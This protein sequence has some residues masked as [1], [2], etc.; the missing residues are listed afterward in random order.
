M[1]LRHGQAEWVQDLQGEAPNRESASTI[2]GLREHPPEA[3]SFSR[4]IVDR[5]PSPMN[6]TFF[7]EFR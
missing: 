1:I 5:L 6:R 2:R 7:P 3:H 4:W